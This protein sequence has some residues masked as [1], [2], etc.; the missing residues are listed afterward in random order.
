MHVLESSYRGMRTQAA[1][2]R[3]LG[4]S[5][6]T[7]WEMVVRMVRHRLVDKSDDQDTGRVVVQ[8]TA[9]GRQCVAEARHALRYPRIE[10][11][12]RSCFPWLVEPR[13]ARRNVTLLKY[14][15]SAVARGFG[16]TSSYGDFI[17]PYLNPKSP[18]F[19]RKR[20]R[21]P[22]LAAVAAPAPTPSALPARS[23]PTPPHP[24]Q[25]T[26]PLPWIDDPRPVNA[27]EAIAAWE[28]G[29]ASRRIK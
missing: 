16:D 21:R 24:P 20:R 28:A 5:R 18:D 9:K 12:L 26:R 14:D 17:D 8:L 4:V 1:L 11:A 22:I 10:R 2:A 15:V 29:R 25:P 3:E 27:I 13:R 6:Q 19:G 23:P 7:I